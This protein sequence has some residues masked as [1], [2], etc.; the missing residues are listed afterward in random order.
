M[1]MRDAQFKVSRRESDAQAPLGDERLFVHVRAFPKVVSV[2]KN[3]QQH[4][5]SIKAAKQMKAEVR[6]WM[7]VIQP[8]FIRNVVA[9][10]QSAAAV[11]IRA[12]VPEVAAGLGQK[13][14]RPFF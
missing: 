12:H 11:E 5:L 9:N 13:L 8:E 4:G 1:N 3:V 10:A 7:A 6:P 14:H 2:E